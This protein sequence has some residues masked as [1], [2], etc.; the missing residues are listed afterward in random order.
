MQAILDLIEIATMQ[1]WIWGPLMG[2]VCGVDDFATP[3][4]STFTRNPGAED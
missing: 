4:A 2:V 3:Q 1:A